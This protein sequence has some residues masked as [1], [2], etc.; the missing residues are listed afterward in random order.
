MIMS[1]K[2]FNLSAIALLASSLF[3]VT[4]CDDDSP[5]ENAAQDVS[6][7]LEDAV[8]ELDTDRSVGEKVGDAIEDT[9]EKVQDLAN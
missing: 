9:G 8:E 3:L 7:G 4:A 2:K 1:K 5:L 6:R